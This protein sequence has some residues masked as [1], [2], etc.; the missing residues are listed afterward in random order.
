MT[1]EQFGLKGSHYG[2]SACR[3]GDLGA[4]EYTLVTIAADASPSVEPFRADIERCIAAIVR[5]C[6]QSPRADNL[7]LRVLSFSDDVKE[8]HGLKPLAGCPAGDY[9]GC[10]PRGG[11]TALADAAM[12]GAT[13]LIDY[14]KHL[15]DAGFGVNG[16]LFVITDGEDNASRA[17]AAD[18]RTALDAA[19]RAESLESLTAVLVGVN[20]GDARIAG[21]LKTF[22]SEAGFGRYVELDRADADVLARLADFVGRSICAQSLALGTGRA[23]PSLSF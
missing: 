20:V 2:F 9:D 12:N 5:A 7:L 18:V 11:G 22:Q 4:T 23:S 13:A 3:I 17:K 1:L 16:I 6:R 10:L 14:G 15:A 21:Y 19:Q 8:V